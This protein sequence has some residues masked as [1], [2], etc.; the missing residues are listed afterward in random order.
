M[1]ANGILKRRSSA[2]NFVNDTSVGSMLLCLLVNDRAAYE[3]VY[4]VRVVEPAENYQK[5]RRIEALEREIE[6]LQE[7]VANLTFSEA[8]SLQSA[9][10][11]VSQLYKDKLLCEAQI[12]RLEAQNRQ[13]T[14]K[15]SLAQ[16]NMRQTKEVLVQ[17]DVQDE[18][19]SIQAK[20]HAHGL[21]KR[22]A[23]VQTSDDSSFDICGKIP[24]ISGICNEEVIDHLSAPDTRLPPGGSDQPDSARPKSIR[25]PT[26]AVTEQ[27]M[28]W[29]P[30]AFA[31]VDVGL[32]ADFT[33]LLLAWIA[34]ER[35]SQW[36]TNPQV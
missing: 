34:L 19:Q 21:A 3:Q 11:A 7:E 9:K 12:S 25:Y 32:G 20:E 35:S 33:D 8:E 28:L 13:L 4:K 6:S 10:A 31:Y 17:T 2:D 1:N 36:N 27:A 5:E 29:F 24:S 22:E 23:A 14:K 16:S 15:L 18:T 30:D 26:D